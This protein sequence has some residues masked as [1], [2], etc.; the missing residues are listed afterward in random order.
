MTFREQ[1]SKITDNWF[2]IL[3]AII[4]V[5]MMMGGSSV[6]SS[7]SS[8]SY[9]SL[10]STGMM[11]STEQMGYGASDSYSPSGYRTPSPSQGNFAPEVVDRKVTKTANLGLQTE[12]GGFETA[13]SQ[14]KGI[15]SSSGSILLTENV[16]S[17]DSGRRAYKQ[18]YFV[19]K[20]DSKK[21]DVVLEQF[22]GLAEVTSLNANAQDITGAYQNNEIEL[23][24]ER[25]RLKRYETMF[26]SA[27]NVQ[28]QL[29]LNDRIFDE[30]RRIK[31]LEDSLKNQD[32][33][34]D[35]STVTI[36]MNEKQSE[37]IDV[38]WVKFSQLIK[39]F[40]WSTNSLFQLISV[41]LPYAIVIFI[42]WGIV[43]LL[44]RRF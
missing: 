13:Y 3:I 28:D 35:Y 26:A 5:F 14:L 10:A 11:K 17:Y 8:R 40:V 19:I 44:R 1:I 43:H 9:N 7:V 41:L 15:I 31:Y 30:E 20:V 25:E 39:N 29:T 4:V 34:I 18:G 37:Y 24:A 12:R 33:Q 22:K 6:F 23:A 38:V 36:N 16:N 42:I 21:L 32:Q 2:L 27:T